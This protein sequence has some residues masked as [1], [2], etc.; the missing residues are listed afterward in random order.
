[1]SSLDSQNTGGKLPVAPGGPLTANNLHRS[2]MRPNVCWAEA[3]KRTCFFR[4]QQAFDLGFG[5]QGDHE[6]VFDQVRYPVGLTDTHRPKAA[7]SAS[8]VAGIKSSGA[9]CRSGRSPSVGSSYRIS[10]FKPSPGGTFKS[11]STTIRPPLE[12]RLRAVA[13]ADPICGQPWPAASSST[14]TTT[15]SG[16]VIEFDEPMLIDEFLAAA[17]H[18]I[19]MPGEHVGRAAEQRR[20]DL[21][22]KLRAQQPGD[23]IDQLPQRAVVFRPELPMPLPGGFDFGRRRGQARIEHAVR[24]AVAD[25]RIERNRADG[26]H[27]LGL[28]KFL[29]QIHPLAAHAWR[30]GNGNPPRKPGHAR[31]ETMSGCGRISAGSAAAF[32]VFGAGWSTVTFCGAHAGFLQNRPHARQQ[33]F[34][35][36]RFAIEGQDHAVIGNHRPRQR[37]IIQR[38]RQRLPKLGRQFRVGFGAGRHFDN[39]RGIQLAGK[40]FSGSVGNTH[41][42]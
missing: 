40:L 35:V 20:H 1:M 32:P 17:E 12:T 21:H 8:S 5:F 13:R 23:F 41:H 18:G 11:D 31:T 22:G 26:D 34:R 36:G 19:R 29:G 38:A 24:A 37:R 39:P 4:A 2:R 6:Q 15:I 7:A 30:P 33:F 3:R 27:D 42:P 14:P 28:Q 9:A 25:H 10:I 16:P